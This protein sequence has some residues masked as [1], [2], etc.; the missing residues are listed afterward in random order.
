[1]KIEKI[2]ID[3]GAEGIGPSPTRRERQAAR[4]KVKPKADNLDIHDIHARN[5]Q[6]SQ[7]IS[8]T[9]TLPST[10]TRRTAP[11]SDRKRLAQ[12]SRIRV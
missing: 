2:S 5:E 7:S 1:M 10:P 11:P 6:L 3:I 12:P 8:S 9:W 4:Y